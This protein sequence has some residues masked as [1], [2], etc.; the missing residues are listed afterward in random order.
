MHTIDTVINRQHTFCEFCCHLDAETRKVR[1][2]SLISR[3]RLS[4]GQGPD[5]GPRFRHV[6][7]NLH[8]NFIKK[9]IGRFSYLVLTFLT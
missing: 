7:K 3:G 4:Q 2:I 5:V 1:R 6:K 9:G 8:T